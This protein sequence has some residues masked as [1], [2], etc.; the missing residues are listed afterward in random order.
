MEFNPAYHFLDMARDLLL[1]NVIPD[2]A[3]WLTVSLWATGSLL[4]G[5]IIFWTRERYYSRF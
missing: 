4:G 3:S 5:Y 2:P 1:Y